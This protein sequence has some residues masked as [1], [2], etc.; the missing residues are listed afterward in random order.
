MKRVMTMMAVLAAMF[1]AASC[2]YCDCGKPLDPSSYATQWQIFDFEPGTNWDF[3]TA[4]DGTQFYRAKLNVPKLSKDIFKSGMVTV[5]LYTG[6]SIIAPLPYTYY[7][8]GTYD[9]GD[10]A[11]WQEKIDFEYEPGTVWVYHTVSDFQ[12]PD[13]CPSGLK[14]RVTLVY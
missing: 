14:F 13:G 7:N 9:N 8:K 10:P 5:G 12:Y 2:D 11:L 6:S 3:C 4:D 1:S